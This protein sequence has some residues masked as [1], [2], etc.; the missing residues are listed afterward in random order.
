MIS[1]LRKKYQSRSFDSHRINARMS[2]LLSFPMTGFLRRTLVLRCIQRL[3][4]LRVLTAFPFH[5]PYLSEFRILRYGRHSVVIILKS[6]D[7]Q[8]VYP[9][10]L[11]HI[12]YKNAITKLPKFVLKADDFVVILINCIF[13]AGKS[14][15]VE[16]K[17]ENRAETPAD[18]P[19]GPYTEFAELF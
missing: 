1:H 9:L 17:R 3:V 14:R 16:N 6:A 19:G 12:C 4:S 2:C 11:Y 15:F 18:R 7:T 5:R 8:T 10:I 13:L